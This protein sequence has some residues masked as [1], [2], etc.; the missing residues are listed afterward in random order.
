METFSHLWKI[1]VEGNFFNFLLFVLF[2][3][4]VFKKIDIKSIIEN[5]QKKIADIIEQAKKNKEDSVSELQNAN[6]AIENLEGE[7]K[8][9]SIEAEKSAKVIAQKIKEEAE[10]Q[11]LSMEQ[12]SKKAIEAEEKKLISRLTRNT[13][14]AS[15]EVA[16]SQIL[17]ALE[18]NPELH[19]KYINESIDELD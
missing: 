18:Q 12:N 3:V 7:I 2:F 8:S 10:K 1:F 11:V 5:L 14:K 15:V 16:K 17:K 9:I 4:W 19:D 6:K 13:S